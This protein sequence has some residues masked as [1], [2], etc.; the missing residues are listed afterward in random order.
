MA[1]TTAS[2]IASKLGLELHG[3]DLEIHGVSDLGSAAPGQLT[4]LKKQ[5][6][7][8]I[9]ALNDRIGSFAI[10]PEACVGQIE[11]AHVLS[12][13]PKLDFVLALNE[14]WKE[15]ADARIERTAII[16]PSVVIGKNV[17]I[18]HYCVIEAG[19]SIGDDTTIGSHTV[20]K[21]RVQIGS[22]CKI[23]AHAVIGEAGFGYAFDEDE[24]PVHMNHLGSVVI[25]N[26]VEIGS[27]TTLM[28]GAL[29]NTV[30]EDN[31]KIDDLVLIAHNV[32]IGRN[33]LVA[34]GA[35]IAG[36]MNI[37][38]NSWVGAHAALMNGKSTGEGV[39]VGLGAVVV[40]NL[41]HREIVVG[42]AARH[43]RSREP[44]ERFA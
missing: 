16:D 5:D 14:L 7:E 43:L 15:E 12:P 4:W 28:R 41:E 20:I 40:K 27:F 1:V 10:V 32:C 33:T 35:T 26:N 2:E 22:R 42:H 23:K 3:D 30:L 8:W 37:G 21:R 44:G 13:N 19:V 9:A 18:G 25:G 24:I 38:P 39:L 17:S 34:G 36:S 6:P 11:V 31:V 29:G